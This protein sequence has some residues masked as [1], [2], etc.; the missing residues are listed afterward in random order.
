MS[1]IAARW[2]RVSSD[3]QDEDNQV[4]RLNAH[5]AERYEDS[6]LTYRAHDRSAY[7]GEHAAKLEAALE[8]M[9]SGKF[10][11]L[12]ARHSDRIDRQDK[13]NEWMMQAAAAGGRIE[14]VDEPGLRV[15]DDLGDKVNRLVASHNNNAYSRKLSANVKDSH[16]RILVNGALNGRPPFGFASEGDKY[17]RR[18]VPNDTG[19]EYVPKIYARC[20]A[21]ESVAAIAAWL[22]AE[23]VPTQRGGAIWSPKTVHQILRNTVY[24][25]RRR[26]TEGVTVH[27]CE[28][29]VDAATFQRAQEALDNR[30]KRGPLTGHAALLTGF[31]V[32]SKC[33]GPMYKA[34]GWT[35]HYY[36]R[37]MADPRFGSARRSKCANMVPLALADRAAVLILS[38]STLP[39]T[40]RVFIP[41]DN[42]DADLEDI[43]MQLREL[44]ARGLDEDAEDAERARLR[45][46]RRRL[47][48][49]PATPDRWEERETGE[50][51]GQLF[52]R[53][54]GDQPALRKA[55]Q[56]RVE[57]ILDRS[58]IT[59]V[60][61]VAGLL[62]T[63]AQVIASRSR[64]SP[65]R[66]V[67]WRAQAGAVGVQ[68]PTTP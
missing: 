27:K 18:L 38:A 16:A 2:L 43:G 3:Q 34:S 12:V 6:G 25:G 22:T 39:V 44:P 7:K 8:D 47:A 61:S 15:S 17:N 55:M 5:I 35:N 31:V 53:L 32:C 64:T 45:A 29:V 24:A 58:Q 33:G 19:R 49:L 63:A 68:P 41:G 50:T 30:P 9:A 67:T 40:E 36:Y 46:E 66:G 1:E 28:A 37:C 48:A 62:S 60:S 10:T 57:F 14:F 52:A 11:V 56:G 65:P 54:A 59:L 51:Y 4:M 42:H 20:I 26:N 21:G 13:L 23:G